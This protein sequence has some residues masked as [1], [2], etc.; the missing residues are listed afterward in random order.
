MPLLRKIVF[1]IFCAIYLA[2][3]PAII[4]RMLGFV[5]SPQHHRFVK[6]GLIY[7]SS[8]PPGANVLIDGNMAHESTPTIIRDLLPGNHQLCLQLAGYQDWQQTVPVAEKKATAVENILLLPQQWHIQSLSAVPLKGLTPIT[9]TSYLLVAQDD[10][11]KNIFVVNLDK[12]LEQETLED[13]EPL[14]PPEFI[15]RDATMMRYFT[16]DK[17]PFVI[18]HIIVDTKDKYLWMDLK[19]KPV[20]IEDITDLLPQEPLE[21]RWEA[22]DD[23]II[24]AFYNGYA[25]RINIKA[26][27]IYP[28][29]ADKEIP[30]DKTLNPTPMALV[31]EKTG[32]DIQQAFLA[33]NAS[34]ILFREG[35]KIFLFDKESLDK[36]RL[37]FVVKAQSNSD[38]YFTEKTG[39][40]YY[41]NPENHLLS[42]VQILYHKP[43]IPIPIADP[44]KLK[45]LER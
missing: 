8:N 7:V 2:V 36:P 15:Y 35:N 10:T 5:A 45:K 21:L 37:T 26:K 34:T 3:C 25:N 9:D 38:I 20:H 33:N 41:I 40:L 39:K 11:V 30:V 31:K 27:A 19:E 18:A 29:I 13:I 43:F 42:S 1:Y 14:F 28:H 17:S 16:I 6:T 4:L 24:Y 22:N 12:D 23:K 44:L 32:H